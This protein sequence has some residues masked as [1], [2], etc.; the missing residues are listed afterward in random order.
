MLFLSNDYISAKK[1]RWTPIKKK[2]HRWEIVVH[3]ND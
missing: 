1:Y 2:Q 3:N